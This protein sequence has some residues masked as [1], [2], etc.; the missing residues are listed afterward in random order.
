MDVI[1]YCP[2][3]HGRLLSEDVG[4]RGQ[5]QLL[6]GREFYCPSCEIYTKA[7]PNPPVAHARPEDVNPA[8]SPKTPIHSARGTNAGGSQGGDL[9]DEGAGL[10]YRDPKETDGR[11]WNEEVIQKPTEEPKP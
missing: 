9:S 1:L 8:D 5:V 10:W 6:M 4:V 3:C 2:V 7:D 11:L